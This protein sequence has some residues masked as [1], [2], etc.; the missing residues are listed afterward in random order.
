VCCFWGVTVRNNR[1]AASQCGLTKPHDEQVV[2]CGREQGEIA[3][4]HESGKVLETLRETAE[5]PMGAKQPPIL[6]LAWGGRSRWVVL[7]GVACHELA[8]FLLWRRVAWHL[9]M[10]AHVAGVPWWLQVPGDDGG[11]GP[12]GVAVGPEAQGQGAGL[13]GPP[14]ARHGRGLPPRRPARGLGQPQG[15]GAGA[16]GG[17]VGGHGRVCTIC[18]AGWACTM[19]CAAASGMARRAVHLCRLA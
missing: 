3:L 10:G 4:V 17:W 8:D 14:R 2:A 9:I 16:P 1:T 13:Q 5:G 11:R 15:G 18:C 7:G 19:C 12:A 6:A